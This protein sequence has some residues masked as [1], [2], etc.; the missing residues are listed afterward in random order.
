MQ[1]RGKSDHFI[2]LHQMNKKITFKYKRAPYLFITGCFI[3]FIIFL[4]WFFS[5]NIFDQHLN[6]LF[7]SL[8][9]KSVFVSIILF[10]LLP[11]LSKKRKLPTFLLQLFTLLAICFTTEVYIDMYLTTNSNETLHWHDP[12]AFSP[13]RW[14]NFLVYIFI[15][16]IVLAY[17]FT[18]EW[19]KNEKQKREL[20]ETQF[21]TELKFLKNQI[22]PHFLFNTLNNLYSIAQKNNDPETAN[23]ISKL[24]GLMRYMLYDSSVTKLSLGKEL[25][26]IK[27]FIVLSKL[28]YP[29]DEVI[30]DI[31]TEGD[32]DNIFITPMLLLPFVENAFKHG[33]NIEE[34]TIINITLKVTN[35]KIIFTCINPV[36][37]SNK[38]KQDGYG[39]IGLENVKR[40]LTLLYPQIHTLS[41]IDTGNLFTVKLELKY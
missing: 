29:N 40:R 28:R 1:K 18:K 2:K 13:F 16:L 39:G 22:N 19:V 12:F 27:D 5:S 25:Q 20:I 8:L 17:H 10:V 41:I 38:M 7:R 4:S 11:N 37:S 15:L 33:I 6:T 36:S 14:I 9:I 3:F 30:V 32:I 23:G 24:A 21:T 31:T 34:V 26:N 35:Q